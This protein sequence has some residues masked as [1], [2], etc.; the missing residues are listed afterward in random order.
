MEKNGHI[1]WRI[2]AAFFKIGLFTVGGG[3]AMLPM[4]QREVVDRYAWTTPKEIVDFYAIGQSASGSI[5]INTATCIGYKLKGIRGALAA[6]AGMIA[7]SWFIIVLIAAFFRRFAHLE[8]VQSAFEGIRIMVLVL[9]LHVI[10]RVGKRIMKTGLA[11]ILAVGAFLAVAALGI[12]PV[13]VI[14]SAAGLGAA[15]SAGFSGGGRP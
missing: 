15:L 2:F 3:Y 13:W 7:P 5:A 12:S 14:L 10:V 1:Y 6:T 9:I 4:L 8:A 11:W